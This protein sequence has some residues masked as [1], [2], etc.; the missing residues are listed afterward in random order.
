MHA[1]EIDV[2]VLRR[3]LDKV[4][5]KVVETCERVDASPRM[6]SWHRRWLYGIDRRIEPARLEAIHGIGILR[7]VAEAALTLLEADRFPSPSF[8]RE[9]RL[10][11]AR[12][13]VDEVSRA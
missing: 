13:L 2:E 12:Q 8:D 4:V 1:D 7:K 3:D 5:R 11:H 6:Y 9:F 10:A